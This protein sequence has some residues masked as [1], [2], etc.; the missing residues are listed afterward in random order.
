LFSLGHGYL[1]NGCHR[2][3]VDQIWLHPQSTGSTAPVVKLLRSEASK[4]DRIRNFV[5]LRRSSQRKSST[6]L[7]FEL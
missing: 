2:E 1:L 4:R 5:A 7:T 3:V 6:A